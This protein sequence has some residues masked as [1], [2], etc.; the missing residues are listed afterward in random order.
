MV[1]GWKPAT[2]L[3]KRYLYFVVDSPELCGD[4]RGEQRSLCMVQLGGQPPHCKMNVPETL[5]VCHFIDFTSDQ[6]YKKK[7]QNEG[8]APT[9]SEK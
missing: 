4:L 6:I 5:G 8:S 1:G 7:I 2:L 9:S 3:L